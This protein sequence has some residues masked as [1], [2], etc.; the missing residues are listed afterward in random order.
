M[1]ANTYIIKVYIYSIVKVGTKVE[2]ILSDFHFF[3]PIL[4]GQDLRIE[5]NSKQKGSFK[6][7]EIHAYFLKTTMVIPL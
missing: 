5:R 6:L 4:Q 7:Q 3:S 2:K 1:N